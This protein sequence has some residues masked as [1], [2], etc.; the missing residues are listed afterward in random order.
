MKA[1]EFAQY[2]SGVTRR[3]DWFDAR[4]PAHK[5]RRPSLSFKDGDKGLIVKCHAGCSLE[6]IVGR[7]GLSVRDLFH[8]AGRTSRI[9]AVYAYR[10][11]R[12]ELL[13]E[14]VRFEPKSFAMRR[15]D[16]AGGWIWNM[17]GVRRVLYRLPELQGQEKVYITEGEK[18]ADALAALGLPATTSAWGAAGWREEYADQLQTAGVG[19]VIA[20]PDNDEAGESYATA[21]TASCR[22]VGID[23]AVIRMPGLPSSGDVTDWLEAGGTVKEL[24]TLIPSMSELQEAD[25]AG[26]GA[27]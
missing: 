4:C 27:R 17:S 10:G 5:D 18:D 20:L 15:P 26:T 16:G 21:M 19:R 7:L 8:N 24:Q 11:E 3:G 13:Y 12:G 9:A 14:V 25:V 22:R 2:F 6:Q 1:A 23:V